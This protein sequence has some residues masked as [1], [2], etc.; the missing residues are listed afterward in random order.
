MHG[1]RYKGDI[2]AD[3]LIKFGKGITDES[4]KPEYQSEDKPEPDVVDNVKI[5]VGTTLTE[6]T[7]DPTKDVMLE[8]YA[9]WCGHCKTLE[10]IYKELAARFKDIDSVVIA[11][12]D[13]TANE[14]PDLNVDGYPSVIFFPAAKD[15]ES[16]ALRSWPACVACLHVCGSTQACACM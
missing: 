12:I 2:T 9:P 16:T 11:K 3:G 1:F 10:P 5:V 8:V 4:I 13:G 7:S 15:A 6:V 14:H